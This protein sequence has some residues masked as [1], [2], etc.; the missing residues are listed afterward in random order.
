MPLADAQPKPNPVI[1]WMRSQVAR[2]PESENT[3][4]ILNMARGGANTALNW[5]DATNRALQG[6][7][8][9]GA[10][11]PA[12]ILAPLG[13]SAAGAPFAVRGAVGSAGGRL[14]AAQ[15]GIRAYHGSPHDF[16]R[17]DMSKIGTG[18]GAQA[19]GHG[20]YFAESE[21]VAKSYRDALAD[22]DWSVA[23]K[24]YDPSNPEHFA[25]ATLAGYPSAEAAVRDLEARIA[26]HEKIN[27]DS[28]K[29]FIEQYRDVIRRIERGDLPRLEETSKGRLYEVR[30][31]ANPDEFLDWD[32]PLSQQ[33]Q[34]IQEVLREN[35]TED[36]LQVAEAVGP[37]RASQLASMKGGRGRMEDVLREAGIPGIKYLDQGSRAAGEGSRNYVLFRDDIID[38]IRKYGIA[39]AIS[40][41]GFEAVQGALGGQ[42]ARNTQRPIAPLGAPQF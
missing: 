39:A 5:L 11:E 8:P 36:F 13:L 30:I 18:E 17:F 32:K 6:Y 34:R 21:G 35:A 38:I 10:L 14:S 12:D 28:N 37:G 42:D 4:S 25:A 7:D 3:F 9:R 24:P 40:T 15:P 1:E 23:G 19:Y 27:A 20:L 41:Y 22:G 2:I 26:K 16:D 33:P 31:N 29:R